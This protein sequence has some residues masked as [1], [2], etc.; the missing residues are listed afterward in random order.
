LNTSKCD[1]AVRDNSYTA[2][3]IFDHLGGKHADRT[4]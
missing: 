2:N 4:H 1:D 3:V